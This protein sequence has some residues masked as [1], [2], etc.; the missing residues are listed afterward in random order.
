MINDEELIFV[1]DQNDNPTQPKTRRETHNHHLW[2]RVSHIWIINAQKQVLCQKRKINKDINPGK[3]EAH[4]GGHV[5]SGESYTDNA[6]KET[7]E[8]IGL[9]K[10]ARDMIFF[11][12]HKYDHAREFQGIF[13]TRWDGDLKNLALEEEEVECVTWKNIPELKN[14]FEEKDTSWV[15]DEYEK[16]I[17]LTIMIN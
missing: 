10:T 14:I 11:K 17:L 9:E 6:I 16:D 5:T 4:F 8:E 7:K 1:V 2:H 3:W 13:Y 15:Q 12:T